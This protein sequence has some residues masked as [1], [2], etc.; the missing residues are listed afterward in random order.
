MF[1]HEEIIQLINKELQHFNWNKN[2][3]GLY[4]PIEYVLSLG[5]KRLRPTLLLLS[6]NLFS[7]NISEAIPP[8]LGIEIFHS[9]TLLHD[10]LMDKADLRRGHV[11]VHKKW[12]ENITILSGDVMQTIAFQLMTKAPSACLKK[13]LDL[14]SQ[15]AIE[16]CEGQQYDMEFEKRQEVLPEEYLEMIRLKTAVLLGASMKIGAWIGGAAEED[17]QTL[18]EAGIN[19]G[20]A[21]QLKDDLLDVYGNSAEFGKKIGGDIL[22]NKKTFL[23]IQA[24]NLARGKEEKILKKWLQVDENRGEEKVKAITDVYNQL[25]IKEIC[26]NEIQF[27]SDKALEKLHQISVPKNKKSELLRLTRQ[28]V[29]RNE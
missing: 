14:F 28:L 16:V 10:D 2:P 12:N 27:F 22:C 1:S 20:I 5:G 23:L 19:M 7:E 9:F 24:L 8:A 11:T 21:F 25:G 29:L 4:E 18:Y 15:T 17:A 26:E 3:Y 6:C 13:C